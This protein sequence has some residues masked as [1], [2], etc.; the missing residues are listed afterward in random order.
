MFKKLLKVMSI[1]FIAFTTFKTTNVYALTEVKVGNQ[2]ELKEA[3]RN[4]DVD[5]ITLSDN[6][7]STEKINISRP[8]TI[9]G[10]GH[11]IKYIGT[12]GK[13][14]S[15]DNTVWGGIYIL[16]VYKTNATIRDIK[17]TGGNAA[18]LVNGS[19]VKLEGTID[20]SGNGFGGI[21][22]GQGEGVTTTVKV[23]L[24]DNIN[25]VNTTESADKP[26]FW[27][28]DDS[29]NAIIQ[30]N[31]ITKIIASGDEVTIAEVNELFDDIPQ[32]NPKTGDSM[33]I[34]LLI[35]FLGLTGFI[36]ILNKLI[37]QNIK[38]I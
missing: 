6:I 25:I 27:V 20:V 31:G 34:Y 37:R 15:S 12:F 17:L 8:L 2:D 38:G 3:I 33:I 26:T 30:M 29:D 10:K 5:V 18:L 1:F 19:S 13:D 16:Q 11:T 23:T 21:E 32:E 14:N 7:N 36:S 9:D 28:P 35:G 4:V 22:L 24:A